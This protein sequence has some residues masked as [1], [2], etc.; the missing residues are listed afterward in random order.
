MSQ[1]ISNS[2]NAMSVTCCEA[3]GLERAITHPRVSVAL[4]PSS[5]VLTVVVSCEGGGHDD[6]DYYCDDD[7][8]DHGND[9]S[10][11]FVT[12]LKCCCLL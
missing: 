1:S 11:S 3:T 4:H 10:P 6:D 12:R 2:I 5:H 8:D 9:E 7:E